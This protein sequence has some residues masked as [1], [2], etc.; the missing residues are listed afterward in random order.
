MRPLPVASKQEEEKALQAG[1]SQQAPA[2]CKI[3]EEK[4]KE[5]TQA[6]ASSAPGTALQEVEE[7]SQKVKEMVL[8][9]APQESGSV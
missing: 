4:G 3:I 2:P 5:I 7:A 6:A 1:V 9:K 8:Q